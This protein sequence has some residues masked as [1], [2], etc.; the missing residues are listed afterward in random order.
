[1]KLAR[2][3]KIGAKEKKSRHVGKDEPFRMYR[4]FRQK[5]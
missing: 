3:S 5:K 2:L 1:M 4:I